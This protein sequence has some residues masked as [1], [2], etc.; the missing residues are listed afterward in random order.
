MKSLMILVCVALVIG[1][2]M[3]THATT[4]NV[5]SLQC[6]TIQAGIDSA[7]WYDTVS[8]A[9]GTYS[10]PGNR[11]LDFNGKPIVVMSQSGP[12]V[13]IIDCGGS[14]TTWHRGF[15]F[16][17][18]EWSEAVVKG[19]TITGGYHDRGGGI[20][21][22]P[23]ST[24][25]WM[26][27]SSPT[28]I[29]NILTG[30]TA[31]VNGGAIATLDF[32][33]PTIEGNTIVGNM[34][35][36]IPDST[37]RG[38][39]IHVVGTYYMPPS[40]VSI[41]GN[42][43]AG[44]RADYG[45][46]ISCVGFVSWATIRDNTI[47]ENLADSAGAGIY[48]WDVQNPEIEGNTIADNDA[49]FWGGGIACEKRSSPDILD[50]TITGNTAGIGGGIWCS[51]SCFA[52]IAGNTI[53]RNLANYG[54]GID[55]MEESSPTIS[56]NLISGNW[57]SY[58]GGIYCWSYSS[59]T[60]VGNVIVSDTADYQGGGISLHD[61]CAPEIRNNTIAENV[62]YHGGGIFCEVGC[63]ASIDGSTITENAAISDGGG[64]CC[65]GSS[66][67]QVVNSILWE[68]S[69]WLGPEAYVDAS[70]AITVRYSDVQDGQLGIWV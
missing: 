49:Q 6:P 54:G 65:R 62:A 23:D 70:S 43:I 50:N 24:P 16:H 44:N 25:P 33:S 10:G 66:S 11:D 41:V 12:E 55:C 58:G 38:G 52:S 13:T 42:T 46:G 64:I 69:G 28:I 26:T 47:S 61:V 22:A 20:L 68:N 60:I 3:S 67:A 51:D 4:W 40:G 35:K 14:A 1:L 59:P 57:A 27:G 31:T 2:C 53:S 56:N 37:N 63:I 36:G 34:A 15:W 30:D 45:G 39:G 8:V 18:G 7:A 48:C 19:F 29:G 32:C 17:N 5:P 21:V 9:P